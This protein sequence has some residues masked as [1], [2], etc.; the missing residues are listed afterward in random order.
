MTRR[1]IL[2]RHAKS[3]WDNLYADDHARSLTERGTIDAVAIGKWL[4]ENGYTPDKILTSDAMR[5]LQTMQLVKQGLGSAPAIREVS[6]LY[7]AAPQ[8][9]LNVAKPAKGDT[10]AVIGHNPGIAIAAEQL[11]IA[12]PE[13]RRFHDYPTCAT[14]VFTFDDAAFCQPKHGTVTDFITP[15][16]L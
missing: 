16:D 8:T 1:L 2:I 6:Q 4:A 9:I 14:T 15:K 10:V 13:H 5:A 3:G 7:H 11:A 12:P